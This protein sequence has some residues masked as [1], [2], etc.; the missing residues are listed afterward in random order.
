MSERIKR[1]MGGESHVT[2]L[3][4]CVPRPYDEN[5]YENEGM[6]GVRG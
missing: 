2:K 3:R 4:G 5:W 6:L 1:D